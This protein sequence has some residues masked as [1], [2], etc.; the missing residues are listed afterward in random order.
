MLLKIPDPFLRS[1]WETPQYV[2]N[3][4]RS[5]SAWIKVYL[6]WGGWKNIGVWA[7][8]IPEPFGMDIIILNEFHVP[9]SWLNFPSSQTIQ[10]I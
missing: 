3:L 5:T 7:L 1:V 4:S 9:G 10:W 8:L 6:T 2:L